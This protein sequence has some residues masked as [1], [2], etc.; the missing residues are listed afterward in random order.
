VTVV[1][2]AMVVANRSETEL[3]GGVG[4]L[5]LLRSYFYHVGIYRD[6]LWDF[7]FEG[8]CRGLG[9]SVVGREFCVKYLE[10]Q[11]KF[12]LPEKMVKNYRVQK[13]K[14]E[15]YHVTFP[16]I[17]ITQLQ[18]T[19]LQNTQ[20]SPFNLQITQPSKHTTFHITQ[21]SSHNLHIAQP[22]I[23]EPSYR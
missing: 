5:V 10:R 9:V 6:S 23:A 19:I 21:S 3:G 18:S 4:G 13:R 12:R 15:N 11:K 22:H 17:H 7:G 1:D 8:C 20:L 16:L 2:K 14:R